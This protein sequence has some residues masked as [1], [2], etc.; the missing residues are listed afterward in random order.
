MALYETKKSY[1]LFAEAQKYVPGGLNFPRT[2]LFLS[3]GN[4]PAFISRTKGARFWD[5]DGNEYI[6][7]MCSFGAVGLGYNH[8]VVDEAYKKQIEQSNSS[9]MPSHLWVKCAKFL[10]EEIPYMDWVSYGK[11][12]SDV[13]SYAAMV[14]R[15]H[16]GRN[17]IVMAE[18]AYHGLH[19]WCIESSVGIPPEYKTHVYKFHYNDLDSLKQVID[20]NKGKIAAVMLTPVGHWA[21]GNQ[22]EPKPG[23]YEGV[24]EICDKEGMLMIIDDIRAGFRIHYEG[25]HRYYTKVDP[26]MI[27]FGKAVGNGYPIATAMGKDAFKESARKVYWS[28]THFYSAGPMAAVIAALTEMKASGAVDHIY[29]MGVKFMDGLRSAAKLNEVAVNVTGHPAMPFMTFGDDGNFEKNRFFCGEASK[30]GIFLH[31]HHN[32]FISAALTPQDVDKTIEVAD[33]CFKLVA[34]KYR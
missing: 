31:P 20:Q 9:T 25:S 7:Y 3:Y 17:G 22:E 16:T 13:T 30:R 33:A 8:P 32:W 4:H 1:D 24:R 11:N 18:H 27:C 10:V 14:A 34:E 26:D 5:V 23:F 21:L 19:H 28:G 2:P 15:A 29:K 12:G 6:D